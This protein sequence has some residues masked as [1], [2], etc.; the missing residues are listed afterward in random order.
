M[1]M[2]RVGQ[3]A[4]RTGLTV[5]TLHHYDEL[6]IVSPRRRSAAG[7]RLYG[8][9]DVARLL[10]VVLLRRLGLSL[11]EVRASLDDPRHALPTALRA[12]AAWLRT[13]IAHEQRL[14]ARL[15]SLAGRLEQSGHGAGNDVLETLEML[16]MFEKYM[17]EEQLAT[18]A[19][20]KEQLGAAHIAEVEAEWPRL[21]AAVRSAMERGVDPA[22][23]ELQPLVRRWQELVREFTGGDQQIAGAV[24]KMYAAEPA[25]RQR[26]GLDEGIMEYVA[27]AIA[28]AK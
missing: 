15:D 6:G 5:R 19:E 4:K 16:T 21:I 18:L 24:R 11:A 7:Y 22:S 28:A 17:T 27:R 13:Q 1:E 8:E 10:Q 2:L 20:R 12:Q 23:P 9:E 3:L 25:V 26:T 14:L